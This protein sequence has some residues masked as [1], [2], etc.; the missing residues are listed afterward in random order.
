MIETEKNQSRSDDPLE[1][2]DGSS[3]VKCLRTVRESG[4][5]ITQEERMGQVTDST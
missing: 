1:N 2:C 3:V 5:Q 4:R